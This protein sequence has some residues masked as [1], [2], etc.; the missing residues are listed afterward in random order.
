VA[1]PTPS[2]AAAAYTHVASPVTSGPIDYMAAC[3]KVT[4]CVFILSNSFT[5]I[6]WVYDT[7]IVIV[8]PLLGADVCQ[9]DGGSMASSACN[10]TYPLVA[11]VPAFPG[12]PPAMQDSVNCPAGDGFATTVDPLGAAQIKNH[13][14][15]GASAM[16]CAIDLFVPSK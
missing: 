11:S 10:L 5:S 4:V 6:T 1:A 13:G 15:Q 2:P 16:T 14:Q 3:S 7:Y 9:A 12:N 8:D